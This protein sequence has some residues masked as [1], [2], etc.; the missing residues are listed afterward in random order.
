[1]GFLNSKKSLSDRARNASKREKEPAKK[2]WKHAKPES[3]FKR[4]ERTQGRKPN[5]KKNRFKK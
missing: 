2:G 1:M 5:A 4:R 3:D